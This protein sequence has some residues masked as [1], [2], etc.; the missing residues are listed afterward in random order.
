MFGYCPDQERVNLTIYSV[1]GYR[2]R[3]ACSEGVYCDRTAIKKEGKS[4]FWRRKPVPGAWFR[5]LS[6][7]K[8]DLLFWGHSSER[9]RTA[10]LPWTRPGYF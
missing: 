7:P 6:A 3:S 1:K 4:C 9:D 5:V 8:I 10:S 2:R